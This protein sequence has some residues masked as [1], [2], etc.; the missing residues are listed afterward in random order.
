MASVVNAKQIA[1]ENVET[2]VARVSKLAKK[3]SA[4]DEQLKFSLINGFKPM[5]HQHVLTQQADTYDKI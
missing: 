5:I 3:A 1:G 4:T 2:F